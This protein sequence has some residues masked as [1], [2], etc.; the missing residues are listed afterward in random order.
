MIQ[1]QRDQYGLI[2]GHAMTKH[3]SGWTYEGEFVEGKRMGKGKLWMP[4]GTYFEIYEGV[5]TKDRHLQVSG[6]GVIITRDK[7]KYAAL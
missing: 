5:F 1:G 6:H 2:T 7:I 4:D 3:Y